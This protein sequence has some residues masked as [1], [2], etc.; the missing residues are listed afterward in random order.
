MIK[1]RA[2]NQEDNYLSFRIFGPQTVDGTV[3]EAVVET[4]VS[5]WNTAANWLANNQAEAQALIDASDITDTVF[6]IRQ[7]AKSFI[8]DNPAAKQLITLGPD[9]LEAAIENRTANQETLL[10]K[11]LSFAV[12]LLYAESR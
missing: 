7:E 4:T 1:I 8:D 6:T 5:E 2:I 9:A 3:A 10:L 11:T 12:R